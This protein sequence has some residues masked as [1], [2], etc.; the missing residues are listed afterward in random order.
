M[1]E[2][3]S[4][5]GDSNF[6]HRSLCRL[7]E[8]SGYRVAEFV[9][10]E[11]ALEVLHRQ[12]IEIVSGDPCTPPADGRLPTAAI[13]VANPEVPVIVV[14][15]SRTTGDAI[16]AVN[17][18]AWSHLVKPFTNDGELE[19]SNSFLKWAR[20]VDESISYHE[21][22]EDKLL[23]QTRELRE[24]E[25]KFEALF[26]ARTEGLL[27]IEVE[28][29]TIKLCN[30]AMAS[31]LGLTKEETELICTGHV[32]PPDNLT[33]VLKQFERLS[34]G[35]SP[36]MRDIPVKRKNGTVFYADIN[37]SRIEFD[38]VSYF[39]CSFH[40][41]TDRK[42]TQEKLERQMENFRALR[43]ID[44]AIGGCLDLRVTFD[45]IL[46]ETLKQLHVDSKKTT[47]DEE[48]LPDEDLDESSE[49]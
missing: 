35:Y 45:V 47:Q 17:S 40:D 10:C 19:I 29:C 6:P 5:A 21:H 44:I 36:S 24:N 20:Q 8:D 39:F 14:Y 22:L 31:L 46:S 16:S 23:S 9:E 12:K 7:L 18:G 25:R 26:E 28:T 48:D 33:N 30:Q 15:R 34:G 27:L 3:I 11:E 49:Y 41:V 43:T 38:K 32:Q 1:S 13:N 2:R 4:M 37:T 42:G